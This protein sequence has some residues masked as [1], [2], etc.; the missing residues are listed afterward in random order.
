MRSPVMEPALALIE[1][2]S[3]AVGI[4]TGDAMVKRAP[5]SVLSSV[6]LWP[7][8]SF[9][10]RWTPMTLQVARVYAITRHYMLRARAELFRC[11]PTASWAGTL[12]PRSGILG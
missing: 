5:I 8:N 10:A 6:S 3:I 12:A 7:S 4:E 2:D 11:R 1:L 9:G